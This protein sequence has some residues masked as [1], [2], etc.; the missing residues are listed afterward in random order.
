MRPVRARRHPIRAR[1]DRR[2]P[3]AAADRA[4]PAPPRDPAS[5]LAVALATAAFT[6]AFVVW[7]A[8]LFERPRADVAPRLPRVLRPLRDAPHRVPLPRGRPVPGLHRRR[9]V[10][11]RRRDRPARDAGRL[12]RRV[13]PAA[14]DPGA[15]PRRRA[16]RLG[17]A[18]GRSPRSAA[19]AASR[20]PSRCSAGSRASRA[21]ACRAACATC[22]LRDRLRRADVRRTCCSSPAGIRRRPGPRRPAAGAPEAS[23]SRSRVDDD[24]RSGR[25]CSSCSACCSCIPH[26][27]WLTLWSVPA[28]LAAL[29]R[30]ARRARH[31][32]RAPARSTGSSPRT[33]APDALV[34]ASST[35]SA[36]VPRLRRARGQLPDRPDD[37]AA[38]APARLGVLFRLVLALPALSSPRAYGGVAL[39]RRGPRLVRGA[40]Q[41]AACPAGSATSAR[42]RCATRRRSTRTCCS[43]RRATRT[44]RPCSS[45]R[46]EP[47]TRAAGRWSRH[48]PAAH[49]AVVARARG[50]LGASRRLAACSTASSRTA[51]RCRPSTSTPSSAQSS[52][53]TPSATSGSSSPTGCSRRSCCS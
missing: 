13:P 29:A 16:R 17:G 31:R 9:G 45:G 34:R 2:P 50:G 51:S 53:T 24:A 48:E 42:L 41:R 33:S 22:R 8:V 46:V 49:V 20:R 28:S 5:R 40:R 26:L 21:A 47:P 15:P 7:L 32:P 35:S 3:S 6:L 36:A 39:R 44:R 10:S 25:A 14:R 38:G 37:R 1:R 18:R 43:S 30:L 23:R 11:G 27:L 19:S 4:L 52:S 12:G